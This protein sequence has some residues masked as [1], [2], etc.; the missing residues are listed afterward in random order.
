VYKKDL[1][2]ASEDIRKVIILDHSPDNV[3]QKENQILINK[4]SMGN[5]N[6]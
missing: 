5:M 6:K 1:K 3:I 2:I 4:I